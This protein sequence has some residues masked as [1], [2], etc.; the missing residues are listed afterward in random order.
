MIARGVLPAPFATW[1]RKWGAPAGRFWPFP[2]SLQFNRL[3]MRYRGRFAHQHNS[4]TRT[5]EYPWAHAA[6]AKYG[7]ALDI[8]EIGGG[9]SGMQFVLAAEG[10][11]I[12]N[13]DPGAGGDSTWGFELSSHEYLCKLYGV[14]VQLVPD[15][16]PGA[17]FAAESADVVLSISVLEHLQDDDLE[18][19]A[20]EIKRILRPDG[21]VVMTV[22]LFLN[23]APFTKIETGDWG[24]NINVRHFL[25]L[26]DLEL[27]FGDPTELLGFDAFCPDAVLK[28]ASSYLISSA[29]SMAQCMIGRRRTGETTVGVEPKHD[30]SSSYE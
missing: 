8:V 30:G 19:A 7:Q 13:V 3:A 12:V 16:L 2:H 20:A 9:L 18:Q 14:S 26:T 24:R 15:T 10:H 21:I 1:N 6:I 23:L 11:H 29:N 27:V 17:G 22:D 4:E 5:F 25:E 28:N